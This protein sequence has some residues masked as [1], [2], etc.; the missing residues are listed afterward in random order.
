NGNYSLTV[1]TPIS[2]N[3]KFGL[4]INTVDRRK[5]VS[6]TY[7]VYSIELFLDNKKISTVLFESIPF[8]KTRAIHS[9]IDYPY[10]K[11]SKVRVQKSFK[12]PGNPIE[13]YE[14]LDNNGIM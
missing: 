8:D 3:G 13:I 10:W 14:N 9:Y 2:V 4:G 12:Q 1:N 7:G 6:F 5:G 11:K